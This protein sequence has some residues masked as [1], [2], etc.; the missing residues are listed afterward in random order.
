MSGKIEQQFLL[1]L[2]NRLNT[3][4]K[5][6]YNKEVAYNLSDYHL[7]AN[8]KT[9]TA[10]FTA[11]KNYTFKNELVKLLIDENGDARD[12]ASFKEEAEKLNEKFNMKWLRTEFDHAVSASNSAAKWQDMK[13]RKHLYPNIKYI[14]V[15]DERVRQKHQAW[16]GIVLPMEHDFWKT[17]LPPNDWGCRCN[18]IQ[19][20]EEVNTK[21]VD[22]NNVP[23]PPKGFGVNYGED[24]KL[25]DSDHPYFKSNR[26]AASE[27]NNDV[28]LFKKAHPEYITLK[29]GN[30]KVSAWADKND[31]EQN[32][33][34]IT[35][36]NQIH[37]ADIHIEAHTEIKGVKNPELKWGDIYGDY[38][39]ISVAKGLKN[40]L[41]R[42]KRQS[43]SKPSDIYFGVF[44]I[45]TNV[46]IDD[47]KKELRRKINK[48]RGTTLKGLWI[49]HNNE[50]LWLSREDIV[51]GDINI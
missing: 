32:L 34:A 47:L 36:L 48:S 16:N 50:T 29:E 41:D 38:K 2:F 14:T 20:D 33:D 5:K 1:D 22:V 11:F 23:K 44:K 6:G 39:V 27:V 3:G 49:I 45:E 26:S 28:E 37:K 12:W 8:L 51:N 21:E 31:L 43:Q 42:L 40:A 35:L 46:N 13:E 19:V 4:I 17:H 30:T 25:Y 9:N 7:L 24:Q 15:G 10:S 18:F